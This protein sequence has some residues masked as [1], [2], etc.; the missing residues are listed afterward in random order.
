MLPETA[1]DPSS[2]GLQAAL[3]HPFVCRLREL[4]LPRFGSGCAASRSTPA[5]RRLENL[6][7]ASRTSLADI[8]PPPLPQA[9]LAL[10]RVTED[11]MSGVADV[12][13]VIA[14]DPSLTGYVLRLANSALY[15][16]PAKVETVDRA[17]TCIGLAEIQ[18]MRCDVAVNVP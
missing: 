13:R 9:F 14:L 3:E 2:P 15:S 4:G 6:S 7:P 1:P 18:T 5:T 10:R 16:L 17:V 8:N 11:P 12:A